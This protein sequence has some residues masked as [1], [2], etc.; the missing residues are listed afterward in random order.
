MVLFIVGFVVGIVIGLI[1]SVGF[2]ISLLSYDE[3]LDEEYEVD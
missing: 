3:T 1:G 2:A